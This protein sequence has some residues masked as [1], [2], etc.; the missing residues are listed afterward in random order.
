MSPVK[1][2]LLTVFGAARG[3]DTYH[4]LDPD[5]GM[6]HVLVEG[7]EKIKKLQFPNGTLWGGV[8]PAGTPIDNRQAWFD[9]INEFY[10]NA[11]KYVEQL[12]FDAGDGIY[13]DPDSV[14]AIWTEVASKM[15][16]CLSFESMAHRVASEVED[17]SWRAVRPEVRDQYE[18][19]TV[20]GDDQ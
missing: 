16:L 12:H 2:A 1:D 8:L 15:Q 20:V 7:F 9:A 18:S 4:L 5:H 14:A 13:A 6:S 11:D 17:T 19:E 3:F 10:N